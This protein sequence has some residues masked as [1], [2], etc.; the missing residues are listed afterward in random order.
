MP[1]KRDTRNM[2]FRVSITSESFLVE[3]IILKQVELE[4][5]ASFF[6]SVFVEFRVL[7]VDFLSFR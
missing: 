6:F 7:D 2:Y 1:G 4:I 3:L 5:L